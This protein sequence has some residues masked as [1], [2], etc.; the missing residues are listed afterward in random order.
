MFYEFRQNNSGGVLENNLLSVIVEASS[1]DEAREIALIHT[2]VYFNGCDD[3]T[4]CPCCG[5]RWSDYLNEGHSQP[6]MYGETD[7]DKWNSSIWKPGT[8][9]VKIY[10]KDGKVEEY[11]PKKAAFG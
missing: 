10:Y 8:V 11:F 7:K 1:P 9:S 3:G 6:A 5:D 2:P 4:D